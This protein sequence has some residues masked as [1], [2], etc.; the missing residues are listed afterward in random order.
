LLASGLQRAGRHLL[1]T[2]SNANLLGSELATH[3]TGRHQ[4][5]VLLPFSFAE[6]LSVSGHVRTAAETEAALDRYL[7]EG[8]YPEPLLRGAHRTDYLRDLVRA[9]LL[10]DVVR[11]QLAG[12]LDVSF[13]KNRKHEE[14]DFVVRERGRVVKLIQVCWDLSDPKTRARE[15]RALVKAGVELRC[16]ELWCLTRGAHGEESF[17]WNGRSVRI[18]LSPIE[19]WLGR[20]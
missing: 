15:Y 6:A 13:W 8:G 16:D 18:R 7:Q 19:R 3:L 17:T 2:G 4:S 9:T 20:G 10:K 12:E 1:L 14:V 11:R 5:I